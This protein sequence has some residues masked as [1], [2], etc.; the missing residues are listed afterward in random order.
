MRSSLTQPSRYS[1][2]EPDALEACL[3]RIQAGESDA[4][5][6]LY[7]RTRIPVYSFALSILTHAADAED[8]LHDC[9]LNVQ[10]GAAAYR[11]QGKP[12]AWMMTITRN[13]CLHRLRERSRTADAPP[14]DW[15]RLLAQ[16]PCMTAEDRLLVAA[17]MQQL[18]DQERQIVTLHAV[19]GFKHREIAQMLDLGLSTVLS[20][21]RR[22]L[23]KL[24]QRM[25]KE[26][27][28]E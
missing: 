12:L 23:R 24:G 9:Y 22:A 21:Y 1:T 8:V 14:E 13:L 20:K 26:D 28:C 15:E 2:P 7:D 6:E 10:A 16:R 25:S 3:A 4:L 11:P 27:A 18:S 19:A 17:C 5:A